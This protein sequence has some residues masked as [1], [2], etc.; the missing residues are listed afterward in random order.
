MTM[1]ATLIGAAVDAG[2]AAAMLVDIDQHD[3]AAIILGH[4]PEH[5]WRS[6]PRPPDDLM[7]DDERETWA[8]A[9]IGA[10]RDALERAAVE[11]L[12]PAVRR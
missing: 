6:Q 12:T 4:M 1:T 3:A 2:N 11:I 9:A 5:A 8:D 7:A 10:W